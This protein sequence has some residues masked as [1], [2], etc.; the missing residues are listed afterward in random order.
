[1]KLKFIPGYISYSYCELKNR[2]RWLVQNID[3]IHSIYLFSRV[4]KI[5]HLHAITD[6]NGS[7][8]IINLDEY[9]PYW[10]KILKED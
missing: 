2:I 6:G 5:N 7:R 9:L 1:M 8:I 10:E 4:H 3:A